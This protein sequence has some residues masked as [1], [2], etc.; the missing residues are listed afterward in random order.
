MPACLLTPLALAAA[1]GQLKD[2]FAFSDSDGDAPVA[3]EVTD[4]VDNV[5]EGDVTPT[6]APIETQ[7][8]K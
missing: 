2:L 5:K 8:D 7:K 3:K 6:T 1:R 4:A